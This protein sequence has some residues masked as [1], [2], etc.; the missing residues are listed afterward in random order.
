[1]AS[2]PLTPQR[3]VE[4]KASKADEAWL[5]LKID[6]NPNISVETRKGTLVSTL[7][8]EVSVLPA[9]PS[10]DSWGVPQNYTGVLTSLNKVEFRM[11]IPAVT[12]EY[13]PVPAATQ[14]I[15]WHITLAGRLGLI[16]LHFVQSNIVFPIKHVR[17]VD[18]LDR[19]PESPQ[20]HCHRTRWTLMSTQACKIARCS[21]NKHKM[22]AISPSFAP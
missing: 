8:P 7:P 13:N 2:H 18:F 1:M 3:L 10:L 12:R 9:K 17:S 20:E 16:S 5:F 6:K 11:A 15:P 22:K 21:Q 4:F 14:A 19:T